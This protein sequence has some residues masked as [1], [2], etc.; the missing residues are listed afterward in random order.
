MHPP[1]VDPNSLRYGVAPASA[2]FGAD[3]TRSSSQRLVRSSED[4]ASR[5]FAPVVPNAGSF[6]A[7]TCLTMP[8]SWSSRD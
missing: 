1:S 4:S 3:V 8:V 7:S 2:S 6:E 5:S